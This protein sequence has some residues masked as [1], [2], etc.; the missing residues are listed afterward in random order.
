MATRAES[1]GRPFAV[2]SPNC[3]LPLMRKRR[4]HL[5]TCGFVP[6]TLPRLACISAGDMWRS[7]LL[8]IRFPTSITPFSCSS[9]PRSLLLPLRGRSLSYQRLVRWLILQSAPTVAVASPF[10]ITHARLVLTFLTLLAPSRRSLPSPWRISC[11]LPCDAHRFVFT[12]PRNPRFL[13]HARVKRI[14]LPPSPP[15]GAHSRDMLPRMHPLPPSLF[16]LFPPE[17]RLLSR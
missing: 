11:R 13:A 14:P 4:L 16:F 10:M 8:L 1:S 6:P 9:V 12:H 17:R 2:I 3:T 5:C 15:L 7:F